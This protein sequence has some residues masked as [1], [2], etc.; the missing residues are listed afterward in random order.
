M[1]KEACSQFTQNFRNN[2][3]ALLTQDWPSWISESVAYA[4]KVIRGQGL[5]D[6][7]FQDNGRGRLPF[8]EHR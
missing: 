3:K 1:A 5:I 7:P 8:S 4:E 6:F 2:I